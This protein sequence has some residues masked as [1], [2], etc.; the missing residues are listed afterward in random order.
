MYYALEADPRGSF[1][2]G[3]KLESTIPGGGNYLKAID[4]STGNVV[5]QID[6]P[7]AAPTGYSPGRGNGLLTT[8]GGLIFASAPD[9]GLVARDAATG[10]PL[11]HVERT[12]NNASQTYLL[13]GKQYLLFG[14]GPNLYAYTLP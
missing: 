11:W 9:A 3:G 6:Y 8:A 7:T 1:G 4:P 14:S 2:L 5:W 12:T 13:N 10:K